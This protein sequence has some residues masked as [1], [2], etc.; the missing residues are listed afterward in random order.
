MFS[1]GS[2][3]GMLGGG[4]GLDRI[5]YHYKDADCAWTVLFWAATPVILLLLI[6]FSVTVKINK[7]AK[8]TSKRIDVIGGKRLLLYESQVRRCHIAKHWDSG[9]SDR[10]DIGRT[11]CT[12]S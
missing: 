11:S 9:I 8:E 5:N 7:K 1:V 6:G 10:S 2:A 12:H 3:V 4:A